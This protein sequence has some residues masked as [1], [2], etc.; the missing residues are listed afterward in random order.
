MKKYYILIIVVLLLLIFVYI[1]KIKATM[2]REE[3]R[4]CALYLERSAYSYS[5]YQ[6]YQALRN[7][8]YKRC[9]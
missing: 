3:E 7:G 4:L 9:K 6:Q 1:P 8:W 5:D 2:E